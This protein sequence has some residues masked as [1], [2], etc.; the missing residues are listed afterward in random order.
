MTFLTGCLQDTRAQSEPRAP[1]HGRRPAHRTVDTLTVF[2]LVG[3]NVQEQSWHL[4]ATDAAKNLYR[5]E[6]LKGYF[7]CE[8]V[9][10]AGVLQ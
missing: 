2:A 6:G 9:H 5:I 3:L 8:R 1:R 7:L 4:K 10:F